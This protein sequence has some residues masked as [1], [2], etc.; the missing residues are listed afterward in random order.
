MY[1]HKTLHQSHER[2]GGRK[3]VRFFFSLFLS[4]TTTKIKKSRQI[5]NFLHR[6]NFAEMYLFSGG[7]HISAIKET[8]TK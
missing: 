6:V 5:K 2:T 7:S 4:T 1:L 8:F 3:K